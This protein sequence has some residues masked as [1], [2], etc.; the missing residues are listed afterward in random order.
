VQHGRNDLYGDDFAKIWRSAQRRRS[1]DVYFWF[2]DIFKRWQSKSTG[3][4]VGLQFRAFAHK[5]FLV[6]ES[7]QVARKAAKPKGGRSGQ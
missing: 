2:T 6:P 5:P 3:R 4:Y 7:E 1:D